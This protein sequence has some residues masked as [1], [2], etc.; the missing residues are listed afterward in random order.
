VTRR[1]KGTSAGTKR[2]A[3]LLAV[4]VL[5]GG[6]DILRAPDPDVDKGNQAYQEG[7]YQEALGHYRSAE[8]RGTDA[9]LHFDMGAAL[10][11]LG[12]KAADDEKAK[13]LQ[14][15]EEQFR[16]AADTDDA[17]LKSSAYYNLG[18]GMYQ[19]QQWDD[20]IAS[21]K[22]ALRA[23]PRN[24][25]ARHNLEMALRQRKKQ[26]KQQQGQGQGQQDQQQQGQQGP[27]GQQDQKQPG[28]QQGQQ[29]QDG[30][31]GRKQAP[32]DQKQPGGQ[33]EQPD[34]PEQQPPGAKGQ[35]QD[36]DQQRQQPP[37]QPPP[38]QDDPQPAEGETADADS[39]SD[40]DRKLDELERRSRDLRKRLL[41]QGGA[42][43][44]PLRLPSRK[45]W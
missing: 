20:A 2:R 28:Q 13:L 7:R 42:N 33:G 16:R 29:D 19:R 3:G 24:Q 12:E 21:Y 44:D 9:R 45:D 1:P 43:R 23:N 35:P 37:P 10:Y 4:L 15:A 25:A 38:G 40:Q 31:Q 18:N 17:G 14:Q 36:Q 26:E 6:W 27:R 11:K 39:P 32:D 34:R 8:S 41:R 5:A 30:E 22:R